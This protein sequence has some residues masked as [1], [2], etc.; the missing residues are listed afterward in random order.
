M[1]K[2][3]GKNFKK[4]KKYGKINKKKNEYSIV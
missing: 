1:K 4:E 3:Y 2:Y